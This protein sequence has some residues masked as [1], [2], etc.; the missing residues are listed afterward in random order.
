MKQLLIFLGVIFFS[1]S[2]SGQ[3][4]LVT[5]KVFD[6][7]NG[8]PLPDVSI[9][10]KGGANTITDGNG[11][12]KVN[13]QINNEISVT[14][15][16][17]EA[18]KFVCSEQSKG[19]NI[20]LIPASFNLNEVSINSSRIEENKNLRQAQ[21]IGI[22][23]PRQMNRE[24]GVFFD[25]VINLEPGVLM[26]KRNISGGLRMTIRGYGTSLYGSSANTVT[27]GFKAYLNGIPITSADGQTLLDDIDYTIIGQTEIIKG[28]AS[29]IYG[30]G[31]GGTLK[32]Y[33]VQPEPL[34][35]KIIQQGLV[36]S[37][38]L[39][40]TNTRLESAT[41][42]SSIVVNYGHQSYDGYRPHNNS[43]RD[44]GSFTGTFRPSDK[45]TFSVY[46]SYAH[47]YDRSAGQ[48][49]STQ[50]FGKQNIA[51][52]NHLKVD[53]NSEYDSRRVG[54]SHHYKFSK[55]ISNLSSL[56]YGGFN[57]TSLY[58]VGYSSYA[59]Q[60]YG[61]R[62]E[63]NFVYDIGKV[64]VKGTVGDE[65]QNSISFYK[66]Y[67][68][69]KDYKIGA[70]NA[71]NEITTFQNNLF[72]QW[73]VILPYDFILTAGASYNSVKFDIA[74]GLG[75][76]GNTSHP[77][78]SGTRSFDPVVCPRLSLLKTFNNNVSAFV[79]ISKGYTP[80]ATTMTTIPYLGEVNMNLKPESG[81][82]YEIGSKGSLLN[83]KLSYQVA[84]FQLDVNDK[85]TP[86]S[87]ADSTGSILYTFYTN[88][89]EQID[90][91]LEVNVSY[92]LIND[93]RKVISR[94]QPFVTYTYSDFKYKNFRS[95]N[96]DNA[97][98]VDYTDHK[99]SGVSPHVLNAGVDIAS[100][101][102]VYLNSTY[103]W[104]D[105]MPLHYNNLH[106]TNS[107]SLLNAKIG[108][109]TILGKHFALDV[110]AGANN[111]TNS[112]YYT[113]VYINSTNSGLF[114]PGPYTA[115]YYC[116]LNLSYKL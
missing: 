71:D 98:T 107:F 16:S 13:C 18:Y 42:Q 7:Y 85:L 51:A 79:N 97:K 25:K 113:S 62:T 38:G 72:T 67:G 65:I 82:L 23:T 89:G 1:L 14:H 57:E 114:I 6:T 52:A 50:Y 100:K 92:S 9:R 96:N 77:D 94:V 84:L 47:L 41:N 55:H 81:M 22:I 60:N 75:Y 83:K 30:A 19:L 106:Y 88:T 80:P 104:V 21:S 39:W 58:T 93:S 74:D 26:E 29:S 15:V 91:G 116:G 33:T 32:M 86:Q 17:Y 64:K 34:S 12:F 99:V 56:F 105:A 111:L 20:G 5:G 109:R 48:L 68:F 112:L 102:G 40:R 53:V 8:N 101:W 49:D 11:E 90:N 2:V 73:D 108:Y 69:T 87:V 37:D 10:V 70:M 45:Q 27:A 54:M 66:N 36:G 95:D 31:I 43:N 28:S 76:P 35:T 103:R 110:F 115:T 61:G 46:A 3:N 63:F 59:N 4:V 24:E 44:F 78:Q